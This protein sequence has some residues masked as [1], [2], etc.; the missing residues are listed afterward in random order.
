MKDKIYFKKK[1][2][3]GFLSKLKYDTHMISLKLHQLQND[4]AID[5]VLTE[6]RGK[7]RHVFP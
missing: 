4:H 5:F 7:V 3:L 6:A 2:A 1:S